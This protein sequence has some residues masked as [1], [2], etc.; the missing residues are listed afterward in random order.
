M[1]KLLTIG[2]VGLALLVTGL[3]TRAASVAL[4]ALPFFAYVGVGL[5]SAPSPHHI[6]LVVDRSLTVVPSGIQV[7]VSVHNAGLPVS[8]LVLSDRLL[9]A[10]RLVDGSLVRWTPLRA[11]ESAEL[12]YVFQ[13]ARGKFSWETLHA[14]ASDSFGLFRGTL[15]PRSRSNRGPA[16]TEEIQTF[17]ASTGQHPSLAR[18]HTC[19]L[20]RCRHRLLGRARIP[21]R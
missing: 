10:M 15:S 11:Q 3:I 14:V 4:M 12:Q 5:L 7:R 2:A 20:G 17:S 13:A 8:S 21:S 16:E 6:K 9:P 1:S 19:T 18:S